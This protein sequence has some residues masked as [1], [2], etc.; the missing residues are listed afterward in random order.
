VKSDLRIAQGLLVTDGAVLFCYGA[1]SL[2]FVSGAPRES[3]LSSGRLLYGVLPTVLGLGSLIV[4]VWL[5]F[6][7]RR[8]SARVSAKSP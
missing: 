7:S 1:V 6:P 4:A 2:L 8:E 3:Y 5:G